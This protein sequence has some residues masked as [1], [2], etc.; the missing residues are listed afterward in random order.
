[1]VQVAYTKEKGIKQQSG[2][3]S[4]SIESGVPIA[5][6]VKDEVAGNS[7]STLNINSLIHKDAPQ[8][9]NE[10]NLTDLFFELKDGEGNKFHVLFDVNGGGLA[11]EDAPAGSTVVTVKENAG[12]LDTV[13]KIRDAVIN[14]INSANHAAGVDYSDPANVDND[15]S[16]K[17][18]AEAVGDNVKITSVLMGRNGDVIT[19]ISKLSNL[20]D[21][22][23]PAN[24]VS[25][26]V[27]TSLAA[28]G[29]YK[30]STGSISDIASG[31]KANSIVVLPKLTAND[32]Y[33]AR[34]VVFQ[35]TD[36]E[37]I[38]LK[39]ESSAGRTLHTF[40]A[41]EDVAHLIWNG[42][43]WRTLFTI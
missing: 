19:S 22:A 9:P 10:V 17:F 35:S 11:E 32:H 6:Q 38:I 14:R 27:T 31:A 26:I 36:A 15:I 43:S 20:T 16:A 24:T 12:Q 23:D 2:T 18:I 33:G 30:L 41:T 13:A 25:M 8:N 28:K 40:N 39:E 42:T 21:G 34:K 7:S 1:M 29:T 37:D 3:A 4:F 5:G